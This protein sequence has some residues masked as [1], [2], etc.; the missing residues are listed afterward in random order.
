MAASSITVSSCVVGKQHADVV[1]VAVVG[2]VLRRDE[3]ELLGPQPGEQARA[4]E[5]RDGLARHVPEAALLLRL[6]E[7]RRQRQVEG[8][9]RLRERAHQRDGGVRRVLQLLLGEAELLEGLDLRA[10]H[11][12]EDGREDLPDDGVFVGVEELLDPVLLGEPPGGLQRLAR[13]VLLEERAQV[14]PR[15]VAQQED[16]V[17]ATHHALSCWCDW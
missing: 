6:Q 12:A 4:R 2:H 1:L 9:R 15:P 3:G 10:A 14:F 7:D 16:V 17:A 8:L 5:R 13:A 11:R